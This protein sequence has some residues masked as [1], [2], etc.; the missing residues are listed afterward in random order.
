[1]LSGVGG[2]MKGRDQSQL[3]FVKEWEGAAVN[4][5]NSTV[6]TSEWASWVYTT[7]TV[8]GSVCCE[9]RGAN[10]LFRSHHRLCQIGKL[11]K[12]N[13]EDPKWQSWQTHWEKTH[14]KSAEFHMWVKRIWLK[15]NIVVVRVQKNLNSVF[16]H[17]RVKRHIVVNSVI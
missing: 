15:E 9:N 4:R 8:Q 10:T 3:L 13:T 11:W 5:V 2:G 12:V 14:F 17:Y 6:S 16:P 1:M 7:Y